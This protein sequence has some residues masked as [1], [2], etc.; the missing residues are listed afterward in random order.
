MTTYPHFSDVLHLE[1]SDAAFSAGWQ[2]VCRW[3][4]CDPSIE[5]TDAATDSGETDP[6]LGDID[7]LVEGKHD[8]Q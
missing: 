4:G 8:H 6:P 3:H 2:E 5:P 7:H 1:P